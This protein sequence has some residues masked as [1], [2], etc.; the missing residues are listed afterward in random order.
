MSRFNPPYNQNSGL[1]YFRI[2]SLVGKIKNPKLAACI[3]FIGLLVL[4]QFLSYQNYIISEN[5]L[6]DEMQNELVVVKDKLNSFL[7][8]SLVVTKTLAYLVENYGEPKNFQSIGKNLLSG[9]KYIDALELTKQGE[10]THVYPLKGHEP[11][12]GYDILK[13]S[14]TRKEGL[15]AIQKKELFFAGPLKLKQ[16]NHGIVGRSAIFRDGKFIGF[17][18]VVVKLDAL[19]KKI[20]LHNSENRKFAFQL[21]KTNPNTG[22]EEYFLPNAIHEAGKHSLSI[23]IPEGKWRIFIHSKENPNRTNLLLLSSIGLIISLLAACFVYYFVNQPLVLSRLVAEKTQQIKETESILRDSLNR[24]EESFISLNTNWEYTYLNKAAANT[25]PQGIANVIGKTI[26]E[27]HPELLQ[28]PFE[29]AFRKAMQNQQTGSIESYYKP[30][31]KYFYGKIYPSEKGLTIIYQDISEKKRMESELEETY[32][33]IRQLNNYLQTIR[34]EERGNIAR[35]IHDELGQQL[36]AIKMDT[37][38]LSQKINDSNESISQKIKDMLLLIDETIKTIRKIATELRPGI[39][40]DLGLIAALEWLS[41]ETQKRSGITIVFET[42]LEHL[43]L[44][45]NDAIGIFRIFQESLTNILRYANTQKV[46]TSLMLSNK[47]LVLN[48]TDYGVGYSEAD[49]KQKKSFGLSSMKERA[50]MMGG[51]LNIKSTPGKG[52]VIK[53][54]LPETILENKI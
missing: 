49:I 32:Q 5:K 29:S 45:K 16:G 51:H 47:E 22:K 1:K 41:S 37:Y 53:L 25:H 52:T 2:D 33:N 36:T 34:E 20:G 54:I 39:L 26:W 19:I 42:N 27:V 8:S 10:I 12:L 4:A 3:V 23:Y 38:W 18:V 11:A 17:S 7:K 13:D 31:D 43:N 44:H 6:R 40:D 50:I 35:E 15:K 46:N 14:L 24:I 21:S 30:I 9:N 48:I 28:T